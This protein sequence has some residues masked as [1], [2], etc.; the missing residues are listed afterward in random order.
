MVCGS[1]LKAVCL[2]VQSIQTGESTVVVAGGMESMSR[3]RWREK[4]GYER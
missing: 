1:G 4:E 2:G 3:V